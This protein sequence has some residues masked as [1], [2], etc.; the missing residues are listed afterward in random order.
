M[1]P[2]YPL[3]CMAAAWAV[4]AGASR[5][6]ARWR[7]RAA[8][9][10]AAGALLVCLQ[11]L[12][13]SI[14]NDRVLASADTRQIAREWLVQN[15]PAGSKLVVEPVFPDQW[16]ADV[17]VFNRATGSGNRWNKW[18]TSRSRVANDGTLLRGAARV[19]KLEDYERTTRPDLVRAYRA[20]GY[21]WVVTG[22]TQYG[23][24]YAD[25]AQVPQ[26]IK[27]YDRLK[28]DADLV[29]EARPYG[30]AKT[31]VPF[32]FDFSFDYYP[33]SYDRPGPEIQVYRLRD[34]T[35]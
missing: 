32:S 1:L 21:C 34:C 10:L 19:V 22:S 9:A 11:G 2:I 8:W 4:V 27:Y 16:A 15:V 17:G 28:Q 33:L 18:P 7:P 23:R 25:P 13:F 31:G 6:D 29:Y 3:L 14:H 20:G 5:V 26:A 30:D 12:V 24:A 35:P